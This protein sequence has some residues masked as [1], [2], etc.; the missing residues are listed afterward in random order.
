MLTGAIDYELRNRRRS[1]GAGSDCNCDSG[2]RS[3][4]VRTFGSSATPALHSSKF[5]GVSSRFHFCNDRYFNDVSTDDIYRM[6]REAGEVLHRRD[7]DRARRCHVFEK[8]SDTVD[9][10]DAEMEH[11][12]DVHFQAATPRPTPAPE[13]GQPGGVPQ[14]PVPNQLRRYTFRLA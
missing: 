10:R 4:R 1:L 12:R 14:Q 13:S 8:C 7:Y 5:G 9:C 3:M 6:R 11:R 2:R